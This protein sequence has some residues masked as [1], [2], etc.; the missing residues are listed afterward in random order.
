VDRPSSSI[1][2]LANV[3]LLGALVASV[4]AI[5]WLDHETGLYLSFALIYLGPIALAT[6]KFGRAQGMFVA[7]LSAIVGLASD[8]T[9][10]PAS[11]GVVPFWN[12]CTRLGV[13]WL[14]VA[15][16]DG[17]H[18]SHDAERR[19]ARTDPLTGVANAR[20]FSEEAQRQIAGANR[21]GYAVTL[22]YLDLDNFKP[23]ND[24]FGH[25][26]GDELLRRVGQIL[27]S[28]IRPTD[29]VAR[30]GGDEFVVL[31]P[32]TEEDAALQ[33]AERYRLAVVED[34][35]AQGWGVTVSV[36]I[37]E[38]D[39]EIRTVDAFVGA[40]DAAMYIAK[41]KGRNVVIAPGSWAEVPDGIGGEAD[42][43][44]STLPATAVAVAADVR[45]QDV[46]TSTKHPI[47]LGH[48]DGVDR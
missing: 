45:S 34:M 19:M 42:A 20:H 44:A 1:A 24:T 18:R 21:Y 26:T 23:I 48:R 29:L 30:I 31:L 4:V 35:T 36:G 11:L 46:D 47:E 37:A 40:A 15:G 38:L 32:H 14:V 3:A 2:S 10:A 5:G 16:L 33:A 22:A 13:F 8:I 17:L 25:S 41:R 9:S 7:G 27:S 39:P 28:T 12:A 43:A 6:W